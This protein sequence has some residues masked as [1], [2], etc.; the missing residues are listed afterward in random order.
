LPPSATRAPC[1]FPVA[2]ANEIWAVGGNLAEVIFDAG[3][4][5]EQVAAALASYYQSVA[6]YRQTVLTAL[7][8]V[9]TALSDLRI[10]AEQSHAL[11]RAVTRARKALDITIDKYRIGTVDYTAVV[12]AQQVLLSNEVNALTV[13]QNRFLASVTLI[14]ALGGGWDTSWLPAQ[15]VLRHWRTC[16]SVRDTLRGPLEPEMPPCL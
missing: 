5:R 8:E 3:L 1:A 12:Q 6:E 4:R 7:Q 15:D 16:V 13:R 14:A 9:E 10:M 11:D 2:V